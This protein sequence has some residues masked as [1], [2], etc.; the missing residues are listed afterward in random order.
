MYC[1]NEGFYYYREMGE[2][3]ESL[4]QDY[5]SYLSIPSHPNHCWGLST[6]QHLYWFCR[7]CWL[8]IWCLSVRWE[9][10]EPVSDQKCWQ[11]A[12]NHT[13]K[14]VAASHWA[15]RCGTLSGRR[16]LGHQ[17][18]W[19]INRNSTTFAPWKFNWA[20]PQAHGIHVKLSETFVDREV[21]AL[22][23]DPTSTIGAKGNE[24]LPSYITV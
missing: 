17:G 1:E 14:Y 6:H 8:E 22:D 21:L 4:P 19:K 24:T 13:P 15:C 18:R 16:G 11:G 23:Q 10:E 7:Q 20:F 12:G 5:S 2:N 9:T 3:S